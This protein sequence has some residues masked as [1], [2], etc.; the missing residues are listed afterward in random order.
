MSIGWM[1][2][3][4][5]MAST[6]SSLLVSVL[7]CLLVPSYE[8][9]S[10]NWALSAGTPLL[11]TPPIAFVV[12]RQ[13][14]RIRRLAIELDSALEAMR[15]MACTAPLTGLLNRR[16]F[17]EV[18]AERSDGDPGTMI[19]IDVDHFKSINDRFGHG[20]GDAVLVAIAET[21]RSALRDEDVIGR[22]GGEEFACHLRGSAITAAGTRAEDLRRR[23][24][25]AR[26]EDG[27][28]TVTISVGAAFMPPG[29]SVTDAVSAADAAMYEAKNA[30]RNR[31][32]L[33]LAS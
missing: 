6:A 21:L 24:E 7:V 25:S 29:L 18:V 28:I 11:I 12:L 10:M 15:V 26:I 22:I 3:W 17:W 2:F 33:R 16:A 4:I 23:V 19:L 30:G 8:L 31:V 14:E 9:T 5:T 32:V 13:S 27:R 1:T 20:T